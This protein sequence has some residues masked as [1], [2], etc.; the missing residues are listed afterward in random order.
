MSLWTCKPR[1]SQGLMPTEP[2]SGLSHLWTRLHPPD[3]IWSHHREERLLLVWDQSHLVTS[4][5]EIIS[6]IYKPQGQHASSLK[7]T[8]DRIHM[9]YSFLMILF[10]EGPHSPKTHMEPLGWIS[11]CLI[12][13]LPFLTLREIP[14]RGC[15]R[16]AQTF[17]VPLSPLYGLLISNHA[18]TLNYLR[19][20]KSQDTLTQILG[21]KCQEIIR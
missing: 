17:W 13:P 12:C 8:D 9:S 6:G 21:V 10:M 19:R 4:I 15:Y 18:L 7:P 3:A 2:L 5:S 20:P 14:V 11:R 1:A 16:P